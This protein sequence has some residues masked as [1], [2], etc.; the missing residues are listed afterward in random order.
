MKNAGLAGAIALC[1]IGLIMIGLGNF[2]STPR[3]MAAAP[4]VAPGGGEGEVGRFVLS[5]FHVATRLPEK[6][7]VGVGRN[8][9]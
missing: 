4:A 7:I 3:A 8:N 6:E 2:V 9:S 5:E 1:G